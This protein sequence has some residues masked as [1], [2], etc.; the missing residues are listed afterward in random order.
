[1]GSWFQRGMVAS[2][3]LSVALALML[4]RTVGFR[5]DCGAAARLV[6]VP[7]C[8]RLECH[9]EHSHADGCG[10]AEHAA[11][12]GDEHSHSHP[13]VKALIEWQSA[14]KDRSTLP[15]ASVRATVVSVLVWAAPPAG[16][17]SPVRPAIAFSPPPPRRTFL[18]PLLLI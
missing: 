13:A 18:T 15:A 6:S 7:Q 4:G 3:V 10:S 14:G 1:M 2:L 9:P 12:G 8:D 16:A 17:S 5:C 11:S